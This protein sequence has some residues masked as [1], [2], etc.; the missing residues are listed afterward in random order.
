MKNL[1][2]NEFSNLLNLRKI[3]T[4]FDNYCTSDK[5]YNKPLIKLEHTHFL[6][7]HEVGHGL[8]G[9]SQLVEFTTSLYK[10]DMVYID[11]PFDSN[12]NYLNVYL[13]T[14][15]RSNDKYT[16][17]ELKDCKNKR[18]VRSRLCVD[19]MKSLFG[20]DPIEK[21][22]DISHEDHYSQVESFYNNLIEYGKYDDKL[23]NFINS[24]GY[25]LVRIFTYNKCFS[26]TPKF[27]RQNKKSIEFGFETNFTYNSHP[28]I[29]K[30]SLVKEVAMVKLQDLGSEFSGYYDHHTKMYVRPEQAEQVKSFARSFKFKTKKVA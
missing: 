17:I 8:N 27:I 15:S 5:T 3:N 19:T 4:M 7:Q 22:E 16:Y 10:S 21:T 30:I 24:K 25:K 20:Y 12:S 14:T 6:E 13:K 29:L 1:D 26:F 28:N 11:R 9:N 2:I 23:V 18:I